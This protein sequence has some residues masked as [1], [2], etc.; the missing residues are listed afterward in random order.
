MQFTNEQVNT[1]LLIIRVT[2]GVIF[3]AHGAQKVMGWYG[4]YGLKGTTGYFKTAMG[5]PITMGYLSAF[6]EFF[7]SMFLIFGF[8]TRLAALGILINMIVA[9]IKAHL[10]TGFFMNW[11]NEANRGEGYEFSMTLALI[12][13]VLVIAGA[14]QFSLD[15]VLKLWI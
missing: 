13:L 15:N 12:A 5:I 1:A 10:P 7:G 3:F 4:G 8:L 14:G 2:L 6:T 11:N 9:I